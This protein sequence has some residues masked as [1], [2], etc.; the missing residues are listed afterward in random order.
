MTNEVKT[1]AS[2]G[3]IT[4]LIIVGAV[5][6]LGRGSQTTPS[7]EVLVD[8]KFLQRDDSYSIGSPSAKVKLV[9]FGDYQCPA[10][11]SA[12]P[13][14]KVMIATYKDQLQ[15]VFRNFPLTQHKNAKLAALVAEAAGQQGKFWEMYDAL[16]ENQTEWA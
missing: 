11:A 6:F 16:Y 8:Q 3:V 5:F 13:I 9:E 1:L 7:D 2:I 15:F 10:C 4:I 12:E 14:M